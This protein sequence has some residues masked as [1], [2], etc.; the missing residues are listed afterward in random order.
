MRMICLT[1]ALL[2]AL[3]S[4]VQALDTAGPADYVDP[5]TG[6][7]FM[8]IPGGTFTMGNEADI[9]ALPEHDVTIAPF[10]MGRYEVTFDQYAAF[11]N[12][13]GR[14]IPSNEGWG[15]DERPVINVN[16]NDAVAFTLWLSDETGKTFRLPTEAEWEYAARGGAAAAY[17]WGDAVGRDNANCRDC[18]SQYD[19]RM[20]APIGSF[21]P[22]GYGLYD[23]AGNVYEW[24]LDSFRQ[25]YED[26]PSDG[27]IFPGGDHSQKINRGGSWYRPH[28]ELRVFQRCWDQIGLRNNEIGFRIVMVP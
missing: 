10:Y 13:T 2:F 9:N 11:T 17:P 6:M 16:W 3:S 1:L 15:F 24:C 26:A 27:S 28:Q 14:L 7:E 25:H 22:N 18:G 21:P 8:A 20:T 19:K 12:A 5:V 23:M 4:N